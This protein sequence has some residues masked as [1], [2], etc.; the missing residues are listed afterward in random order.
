MSTITHEAGRQVA[1]EQIRVPDNVRALDDAHVQALAGSIALQGMLVPVVVR[2][3]GDGFELVAGFHRIAA[4]RSL[5]LA[6][7]PVVVRD[8]ETEDADRAVEN[9]TR[10]QLNPYEEAKAVRAML[11]RG[12]TEDGAAQALG[13]PKTPVTAR[14][15]ILEL[16]ERAQQLIGDGV[17]ALSAVDQLRAIGAVAPALLDAV[18][19]YL[20]DGNA[21]AAE[22]LTR[23]PGWVL[24]AA[25]ARDRQQDVRRVPGERELARDRRAAAR[26]E[27]RAAVRRGGEAAS[28]AR[29]L[30][31]RAAAGPVHRGRRRPGARRRRAD[32]VRARPADH[33]R[34]PAVP[35][36]GQGRDQAHPRR[37]ETK[38]AAAAQEK[39]AARSGKAPADPL[40]TAKRERDAQ[41]RELTDQAHGANLDLGAALM[42]DLAAV[43]PSDIDVARFFVYALLGADHDKSPYTQTGER[44][45][46]LAA[47]GI[48][49]VVDDL[50]TDVTKTRK[51]GSRGR[52]R[53]DYGDHARPAGRDRVAVEV[54]RRRQDRRRALR[55]R[56]GRDRRRAVRHAPGRARQPAD[57][58]HPLELA[59]GP[60]RQGAA[61]ARR[62]AR[63]ASLTKLEQAVKR[64]HSRL[65][66]GRDRAA[67]SPAHGRADRRGGRRRPG[68]GPRRRR[69]AA[70]P[71]R[72]PT[73]HPRMARPG[74]R[75]GGGGSARAP[76]AGHA[77]TR[78]TH[79]AAPSKPSSPDRS[80]ARRA[81]PG[82]PRAHRAGRPRAAHQRRLAALDPRPR[83]QR[84]LAL[85]PAQ[86]VADRAASATPAAS[87]PPTSPGF[88]AFLALN[89]CVRKGETAIRILAPG[90]RQAARRR[91]ARRPARSGS[92]SAPCRSSTSRR[93]TRCPAPSPS[94]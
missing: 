48:R 30:R 76:G 83:H 39:K 92:S 7:V 87:P 91:R 73:R 16:P 53:I 72:G 11:D 70:P 18:I 37:A 8:A 22:R 28:P 60:R 59:Q 66:E 82:R 62:P 68:R 25:H 54:R 9:I 15:K 71:A 94:R 56:A 46:R 4:A 58:R 86:P 32:R 14:V 5:G 78:S 34:P 36:A 64:A 50:R 13:W 41:L 90:R 80:R 19:A 12:L 33:R 3:D 45:A 17:I 1:L 81:P 61:Q 35:R 27:D 55:P 75:A 57:A 49:L 29:P 67:R 85:Q 52:L 38:A 26:Q 42:H 24:D 63:P 84:P 69:V 10:K 77:T 93:P 43:D 47:G 40:T 51:D 89:R 20:D 31:L 88:R 6:E 2:N 23:E 65:R 44:I 21:W 74:G 79:D